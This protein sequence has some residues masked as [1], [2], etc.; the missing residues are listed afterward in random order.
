MIFL[1]ARLFVGF[2]GLSVFFLVLFYASNLRS[3][4]IVQRFEPEIDTLEDVAHHVPNVYIPM[5]RS[6]GDYH[7]LHLYQDILG[8]EVYEKVKHN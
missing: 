1:P 2:W 6:T 8:P 7:Y 5:Y 3:C 4:L